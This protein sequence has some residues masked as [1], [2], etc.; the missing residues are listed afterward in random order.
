M[1]GQPDWA[2]VTV[3]YAGQRIHAD[4]LLRYLFVP[5]FG[6]I[7]RI[8]LPLRG[9]QHGRLHL[10]ICYVA[11]TLLALLVWKVVAI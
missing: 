8:L 1:T 9:L 11:I 5:L 6:L 7:D 2:T 3:R 4:S 10:Y